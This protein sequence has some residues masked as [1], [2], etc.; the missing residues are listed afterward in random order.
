MHGI[1]LFF[2]RFFVVVV[3]VYSSCSN[4]NITSQLPCLHRLAQIQRFICSFLRWHTQIPMYAR[5]S[6][7]LI[8]VIQRSIMYVCICVALNTARGNTSPIHPFG[9]SNKHISSLAFSI[10]LRIAIRVKKVIAV[11]GISANS[12]Y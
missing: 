4:M 6:T 9:L 3:I 7:T 8:V 12:V 5:V 2:N 10:V 11:F 1:L